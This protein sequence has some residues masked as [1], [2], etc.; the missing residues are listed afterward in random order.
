[1]IAESFERIHRSNLV[2]MGV[3]PLQLPSGTSV[4][5]LCLVG[6]ETIDIHWP[7]ELKPGQSVSL[8]IEP[9]SSQNIVDEKKS[10]E[11]KKV[12][13]VVRIEN[14]REIDYFYAGGVL[15]YVANQFSQKKREAD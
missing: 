15:R 6:D 10:V 9:Q 13:L 5:D 11:R 7:G 1:V 2:G 3:L 8:L 14:M 4:D 12:T